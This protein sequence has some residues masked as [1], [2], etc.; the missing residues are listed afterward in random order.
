MTT[1]PEHTHPAIEERL[2]KI[3]A[4]LTLVH[5]EV[6]MVLDTLNQHTRTLAEIRNML[7]RRN[8]DTA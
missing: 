3:E 5:I 7:R 6:G 4:E 1:V 8:G 2:G